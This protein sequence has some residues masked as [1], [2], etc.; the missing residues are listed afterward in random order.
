MSEPVILP[1]VSYY[2]VARH[3]YRTTFSSAGVPR[4]L[5]YR[6]TLWHWTPLRRGGKEGSPDGRGGKESVIGGT[7]REINKD[8]L[9]ALCLKSLAN[10][11]VPVSQDKQR[12]YMPTPSELSLVLVCLKD[13]CTIE[14]TRPLP[15]SLVESRNPPEPLHTITFSCGTRVLVTPESA[16]ALPHDDSWFDPTALVC[17]YSDVLTTPCP[18]W[19]QCLEE[20]SLGDPAWIELLQRWMGYCLLPTNASEHWLYLNGGTR[21]GKGTI[22]TV[23]SSMFPPRAIGNLSLSDF[24]YRHGLEGLELMRIALINEIEELK[25]ASRSAATK[26]FKQLVGRD[27]VVIHPKGKSAIHNV[28][29]QTCVTVSSNEMP[30]LDDSQG[31][32]SSKL[33][34]LPFLGKEYRNEDADTSLKDTL[35]RKELP[36]IVAWAIE[37]AQK[38]L[39]ALKNKEAWPRPKG[40]QDVL[41]HFQDE[42]APL[43]EFLEQCFIP[44]ALGFVSWSA[45][46]LAYI[47]FAKQNGLTLLTREAFTHT[48]PSKTSWRIRRKRQILSDGTRARGVQGL[49]FRK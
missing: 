5:C 38:H 29:L 2:S 25:G 42:N 30:T 26:T 10:C 12:L 18:R 16:N 34:V 36:G 41:R 1:D 49:S 9:S 32:I 6:E 44:S 11:Y 8:R 46:Y 40:H 33:L 20:W 31:S 39:S 13:I 17:T 47:K 35:T 3:L 45:L 23:L 21:T 48:L 43:D 19:L 4:L 27:P 37:G 28:K 24:S 7:W 14:A 22:S 15:F